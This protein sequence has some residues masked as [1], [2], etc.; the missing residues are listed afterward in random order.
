MT[1][2]IIVWLCMI[3]IAPLMSFLLC[4]E[5]RFKKNI[6]VGVTLPQSAREDGEVLT[7]LRRFRR[8]EWG[9][10]LVLVAVG[11]VCMFL[12]V[13]IGVTLLLCFLWVDVCVVLPVVP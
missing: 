12:P 8:W 9:I 4:N 13:S 5:T 2:R 1:G 6:V 10:C 11:L 3:W 7:L